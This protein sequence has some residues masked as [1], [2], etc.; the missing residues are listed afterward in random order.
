MLIAT[1]IFFLLGYIMG[2]GQ[3]LLTIHLQNK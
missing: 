2:A 1:G 3:V